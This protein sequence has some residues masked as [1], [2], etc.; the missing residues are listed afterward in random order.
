MN[1]NY[2]QKLLSRIDEIKIIGKN[3]EIDGVVCNVAALVRYGAELRLVILEYDEYFQDLI[4]EMEMY[5][6]C[7]ASPAPAT[8]RMR[9]KKRDKIKE[10][11][12]FK[13]LKSIYIGD[14]EFEVRG[15][16]NRRL[17]I[18]DGESILFLSE[19]LRSGWS[20]EG[21]DYQNIDMMFLNSIELV[22]DF[23]KIPDFEDTSLH[24]V[25]G[26]DIVT[27]VVELPVNL[28]VNGEYPVIWF[29]NKETG[30]ENWAQ[31]NRVYLM[32]MWNEMGKT[33]SEPKLLEQMT[34]DQ[35]DKAKRDFEEKF[36]DICPRGMCYPVVEY[37]CEEYF[38][39]QFYT[40]NYLESI[41]VHKNGSMGFTMS[42]EKPTGI[43]GMK[44]KAAIIQEPVS[45]DTVRIEAELFQYNKT[46]T[47]DDIVI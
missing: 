46:V 6:P 17:D 26:K 33:F 31:I 7:E 9:M 23:D 19:L 8:N 36:I 21:I 15:W 47:P 43:L 3:A 11:Q 29:K 1:I 35:I 20:A 18:K 30:E 37:E 41:P 2:L 45:A 32:D 10:I 40:K 34:K 24:F 44:L 22:G 42:T 13:A 28:A 38:S 39:L 12:P 14:S 4:E 5:E 27:Y 16:E 25:M